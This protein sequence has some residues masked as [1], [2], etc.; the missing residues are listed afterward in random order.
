MYYVNAWLE[1]GTTAFGMVDVSN[2][3]VAWKPAFK[4]KK[5]WKLGVKGFVND[6]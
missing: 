5:N 1:K 6:S 2:T 3:Q 4:K